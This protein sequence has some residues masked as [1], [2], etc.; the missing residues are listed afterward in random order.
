[1]TAIAF[2]RPPH[3]VTSAAMTETRSTLCAICLIDRRTGQP[4]RV[5]GSALV[6][7]SRM[8]DEAAAELLEGRD[9]AVWEVQIEPLGP[10]WRK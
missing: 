7:F 2:A 4:H 8:P 3:K 10:E 6:M 5:N 9:P 1:M